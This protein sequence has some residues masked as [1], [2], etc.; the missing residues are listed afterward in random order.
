MAQPT[1]LTFEVAVSGAKQAD[2]DNTILAVLT[3]DDGTYQEQTLSPDVLYYTFG[4][5]TP[6]KEY[7]VR[8]QKSEE[9]FAEKSY[10]TATTVQN[11]GTL[12]VKYEGTSVVISVQ[13]AQL[14]QGEYYTL[15][16]KNAQGE[17][18]FTKDGIDP[19][20]E[21]EFS[22]SSQQ[23]LYFSLSISGKICAVSQLEVNTPEP[24][25]DPEPAPGP[26]QQPDYDFENPEWNWTD[27][28]ATVSFADKNG[29]NPLVLEATTTSEII[30]DADCENDGQKLYTATAEYNDQTFTDTQT[31]T[32]AAYGHYYQLHEKIDPSCE[33]DGMEEYN[34]CVKCGKYFD[35]DNNEVTEESLIIPALGHDIEHHDAQEATCLGVGWNAYDTCSRC[36][37]TTYQEI[38]ELGHDIEHHDGQEATCLEV[39][40][41]AYDTCSRCDYTTYEEIPIAEHTYGNLI[42]EVPADCETTG[43]AAH[44][45]CSVCHKLFVYEDEEYVEVEESD[46]IILFLGELIVL[47]SEALSPANNFG[48]QYRGRDVIFM[49]ADKSAAVLFGAQNNTSTD[50]NRYSVFNIWAVNSTPGIVLTYSDG[51]N[52]YYLNNDGSGVIKFDLTARAGSD[53]EIMFDSTNTS[54]LFV[55]KNAVSYYFV[56]DVESG[57]IV[58]TSDVS[59]ITSDKYVYMYVLPTH[60]YGELIPSTATCEEGGTAAHY[61]CSVCHKVFDEDKVETTLAALAVSATGHAYGELIPENHN[62]NGLMAHYECPVCNKLFDQDKVE[63][64]AAELAI[65]GGTGLYVNRITADMLPASDN[66]PTADLF[67]GFEPVAWEEIKDWTSLKSGTFMVIYAFDEGGFYYCTFENRAVTDTSATRTTT[68]CSNVRDLFINTYGYAFY[69]TV[70]ASSSGPEYTYTKVTSSMLSTDMIGQKIVLGTSAQ[71]YMVDLDANNNTGNGTCSEITI[72]AVPFSVFVSLHAGSN[73]TWLNIADSTDYVKFDGTNQTY[74]Q[75]D[76]N[77]TLVNSDS[78]TLTLVYDANSGTIRMVADTTDCEYVYMYIRTAV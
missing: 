3:G 24:A 64:T 13:D 20:V 1:S 76:S 37:Y 61:E 68:S 39:G 51:E 28:L 77:G 9:V 32:I 60:T 46:L 14:E 48:Q 31:E 22:V 6:G 50:T 27:E 58:L 40:W 52:N 73:Q 41:Y 44:Y 49:T 18:V 34:Q 5:L 8:I 36:D 69:Y 19:N 72:A 63:K 17:I 75:V 59:E 38:E 74:L 11:R 43:I 65:G 26:E 78:T 2:Y 33:L 12:D 30:T 15:V 4:G 25:P 53:D 57:S 55:K 66:P 45:E 16:A 29:G 70:S 10:F 35:A 47:N 56:Y 54:Q 7:Y 71:D 42:A 67:E 21:Y 23:N 62:G